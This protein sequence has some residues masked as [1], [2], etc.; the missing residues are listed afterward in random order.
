MNSLTIRNTVSLSATVNLLDFARDIDID[1]NRLDSFVP[2]LERLQYVDEVN[3]AH[4]FYLL[5]ELE[6]SDFKA[7]ERRTKNVL[8]KAERILRRYRKPS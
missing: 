1:W 3:D 6:T 8:I 5:L 7:A 2:Q 4:Q